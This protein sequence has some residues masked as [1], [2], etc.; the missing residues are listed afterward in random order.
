ML[1]K[2]SIFLLRD[3]LEGKKNSNNF[4]NQYDF[5]WCKA[6]IEMKI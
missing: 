6:K 4:S 1:E 3:N 2:S 5:Y